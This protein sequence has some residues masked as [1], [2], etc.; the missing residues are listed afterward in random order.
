MV[1]PRAAR[2]MTA[3]IDNLIKLIILRKPSGNGLDKKNLRQKEKALPLERLIATASVENRQHQSSPRSRSE[4]GSYTDVDVVR[5]ARPAARLG[6]DST[7]SYTTEA[8][9]SGL[10]RNR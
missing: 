5:G 6:V 2:F 10:L 8:L 9:G 3:P 1:L 4:V 7:A